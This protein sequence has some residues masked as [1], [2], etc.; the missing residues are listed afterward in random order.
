VFVVGGRVLACMERTSAGGFRS[1]YSRGGSVRPFPITPEVEALALAATTRLGLD[2]AGIDLL[3]GPDGFL[4]NEANSAPQFQGLESC[5]P[6]V[7][8][9]REILDLALSKVTPRSC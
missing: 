8:V 4:V 6:G 3:F 9:A 5:H 1:N 2:V 7:N